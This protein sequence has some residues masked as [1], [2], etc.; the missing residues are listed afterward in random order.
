MKEPTEGSLLTTD[1]LKRYF[2]LNNQKKKIDN[3]LKLLKKNLHEILDE[4][5]GKDQKGEL[6]RGDYKIQRQIRSSI[7]YI[8]EKTVEKLEELNLNDCI[9]HV[10]RPDTNKLEAAI[11]LG[12]VEENEFEGCKKAK[13]TQALVVKELI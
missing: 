4:S 7:S 9:V 11:K 12:L 5:I 2:E 10:K 13:V 1:M 8:D 6:Q 3:E